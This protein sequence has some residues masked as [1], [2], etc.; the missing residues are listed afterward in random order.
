MP[1]V[2]DTGA[3]TSVIDTAAAARLGLKVGSTENATTGGGTVA[4]ARISGA[5]ASIG[6]LVW[7]GLPL[8]AIDLAGLRAG[9]GHP[10][11]GVL[12][13]DVF[14]RYVVEI[15]YVASAVRFHDSTRWQPPDGAD[16]VSLLLPEQI[17]LVDVGVRGVSG[18]FSTAR[19]EF[20]TGQ[21]GALTLTQRH[22][23]QQKLVEHQQPALTITAGAILAGGV[24]AYVTRLGVLEIGRAQVDAP[25]ITVASEEA[26][27]VAGETVGL[28][29]G[30]VLRRFDLFVNYSNRE[31]WLRPNRDFG[32]PLEFD[33]SGMSLAAT[34]EEAYRVRSVLPNSPA[35]D[36]GVKTGDL[37]TAIDGRPAA[38]VTL[39]DVRRMLRV[40][41]VTYLMTLTRDGSV[42]MIT[43]RTRRMI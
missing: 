42:R 21:T 31:V 12:G 32:A 18:G 39:P 1:F 41:S 19:V 25:V 9:L 34:D 29:G 36:A 33:M 11:E 17:P 13:Y 35:A 40:P 15:D 28:L 14:A 26:A 8:V 16:R 30:E 4:S 22:V 5:R 27:G 20:D 37:V 23:E 24:A 7:N 2:L 10:V 38:D 3:S 43:L 6:S